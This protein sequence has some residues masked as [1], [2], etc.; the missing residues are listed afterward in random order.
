MDVPGNDITC[1]PLGTNSPDDLAK[2]CQAASG[3]VAFNVFQ[4]PGGVVSYCLKTVRSPLSD[5]S[6][7]WMKGSC[8]GFFLPCA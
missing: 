5:Q 6:T 8:Q 1:N 4:G 2:L 7:T 3:C